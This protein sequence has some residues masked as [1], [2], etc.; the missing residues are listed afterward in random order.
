MGR[1]FYQPYIIPKH[2]KGLAADSCVD[3]LRANGTTGNLNY[4]SLGRESAV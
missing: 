2:D 3:Y 1:S 4:K